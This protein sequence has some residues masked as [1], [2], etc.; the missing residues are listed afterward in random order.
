MKKILIITFA[1]I[2]ICFS[3]CIVVNLADVN[4]PKPQGKQEVYTFLVGEYKGIHISGYCDVNYYSTPSDAVTLKV[5]SNL[6]EYFV[7][8]VVNDILVIRTTKRIH[9]GS[10]QKAQITVSV[11]VLE[12][13]TIDGF[14]GSGGFGN[15]STFT[16]MDK[17]TSDVFHLLVRSAAEGKAELDVDNLFIN[18]VGAGTYKLSGRADTA[19]IRLSGAGVLDALDLRTSDTMINLS[20]AGTIRINC[21]DN[22]QINAEGAGTVEYRGSPKLNQKTSGVVTIKQINY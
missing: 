16:A 3:G 4:T 12:S 11:P 6:L 18:I 2:S 17:I 22:L 14:N 5:H 8:E 15:V 1:F 21:S 19:D 9:Y 10:G 20:G 7:I 13:V